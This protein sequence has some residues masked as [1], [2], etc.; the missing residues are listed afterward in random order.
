MGWHIPHFFP[1]CHWMARFLWTF[2]E[3]VS[4]ETGKKRQLN[5]SNW[6]SK[7]SN[8]ANSP[9]QNCI[10][11]IL[12]FIA[13]TARIHFLQGCHIVQLN[14]RHVSKSHHHGGNSVFI[15]ILNKTLNFLL[16]A[17]Q[18]FSR[19]ARGWTLKNVASKM[20]LFMVFEC[21]FSHY[22]NAGFVSMCNWFEKL[23]SKS[24]L[25]KFLLSVAEVDKGNVF[26]VCKV[27]RLK[28]APEYLMIQ[29]VTFG[30]LDGF[31]GGF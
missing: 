9:T 12:L 22:F 23:L 4:V 8:Q 11:Q 31:Y 17:I 2:T 5:E 14:E 15:S 13:Y 7:K 3:F 26:Y 21:P 24:H 6:N 28:C 27:A 1:I 19:H 20:R 10:M 16:R 18:F 25:V 30:R 29:T